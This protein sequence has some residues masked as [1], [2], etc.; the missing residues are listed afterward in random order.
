MN[1]VTSSPNSGLRLRSRPGDPAWE[2]ALIYPAQGQWSESE[3]LSLQRKTNRLMELSDGCIEVLPMPSPFHQ[4][5]V[6]FLFGLLQ[7]F[8]TGNALGEVL[9]APL[10]IRL[11]PGK[12]RDPC[13]KTA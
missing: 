10:P 7:A 9:F 2:I 5:V 11:G 8:V 13:C 6:R 3:Y 12:Y 1:S 4:R